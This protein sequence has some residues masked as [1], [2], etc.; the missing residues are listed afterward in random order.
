MAGTI[1]NALILFFTILTLFKIFTWYKLPAHISFSLLFLYILSPISTTYLWFLSEGLF[2]LLI[3]LSF[4]FFTKWRSNYSV[5]HLSLSAL[6]LGLSVLVRYAGIGFF[7]GYMVFLLLQGNYKSMK[8]IISN[9]SVFLISFLAPLV[10]WFFYT[11]INGI[12]AHDRK[13]NYESIP[14]AK[15][16]EMFLS[17]GSWIFGNL[18]GLFFLAASL[19]V[20]AILY[21]RKL[22]FPSECRF[23]SHL[24][25]KMKLPLVLG[26]V[27]VVFILFSASF[28][29]HAIPLSNRIFSPVYPFFLISVGLLMNFLSQHVYSRLAFLLLLIMVISYSFRSIPIDLN[30]YKNGSGFS[31][32]KF[33]ESPTIQYTTHNLKNRILYTN[34]N[35]LLKLFTKN[36]IIKQLPNKYAVSQINK[37]K[38]HISKGEAVIIYLDSVNWRNYVIGRRD[39]LSNFEK[40]TVIKFSDG[41]IIRKK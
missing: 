8:T 38:P 10:P 18:T 3:L 14:V 16:Q 27:Y 29:D 39:L 11:R 5:L 13:F 33:R 4:W 34:D 12:G 35:F 20:L 26:I 30:H 17:F 28:L 36:E 21:K 37:I 24:E 9:F 31:S 32:K 19:L 1:G 41:V 7:M 23:P 2:I 40:D 25:K 15:F 6:I 22:K